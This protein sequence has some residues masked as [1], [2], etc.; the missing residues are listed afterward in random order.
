[1]RVRGR[2]HSAVGTRATAKD[3]PKLSQSTRNTFIGSTKY[4]TN[5]IHSTDL[6]LMA[7]SIMDVHG[8]T[9]FHI[10]ASD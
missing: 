4:E 5:A 8:D 6:D 9:L 2:T 7:I 10:P 1:M 3:M